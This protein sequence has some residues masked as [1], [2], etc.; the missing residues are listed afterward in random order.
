MVV[1]LG[2]MLPA[3]EQVDGNISLHTTAVDMH[4][5]QVEF[6]MCNQKWG[7]E[8]VITL[9]DLALVSA[10][11]ISTCVCQSWG[12]VLVAWQ[13]GHDVCAHDKPARYAYFA[14]RVTC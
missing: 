13:P 14:Y 3:K 4:R 1:R 6:Q 11:T 12:G 5:G 2:R 8:N 10:L 7:E 9:A